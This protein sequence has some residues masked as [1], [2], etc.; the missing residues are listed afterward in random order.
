MSDEHYKTLEEVL[1]LDEGVKI[2][3]VRGYLGD[4][5]GNGENVFCLSHVL[6]SNGE[7]IYIE[8]EHDAAYIPTSDIK[9]NLREVEEDEE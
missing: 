4:P 6:L 9:E 5:F 2:V 3:S 7:K 8:G 1:D